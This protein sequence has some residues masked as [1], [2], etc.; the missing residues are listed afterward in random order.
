MTSFN[1]F[2]SLMRSSNAE[3]STCGR[4]ESKKLAMSAST[5]Q[6]LPRLAPARIASS[7]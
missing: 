2:R 7:A 1:I 4:I 3:A 6:T 5:T